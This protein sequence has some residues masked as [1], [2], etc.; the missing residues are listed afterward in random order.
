MTLSNTIAKSYLLASLVAPNL[1]HIGPKFS[2]SRMPLILL[3]NGPVEVF[4]LELEIAGSHDASP[5][6]VA[7]GVRN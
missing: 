2:R 5:S 1:E 4:T 7:S 6:A 3:E